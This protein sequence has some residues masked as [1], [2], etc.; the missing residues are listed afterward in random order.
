MDKRSSY[1]LSIGN[2]TSMIGGGTW[3]E[4][5]LIFQNLDLQVHG[6]LQLLIHFHQKVTFHKISIISIL[7]M[8]LNTS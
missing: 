1:R 2:L 5:F 6:C 7:H 4:K 3:R 8:V